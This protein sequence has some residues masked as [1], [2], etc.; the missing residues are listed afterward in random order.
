M[1]KYFAPKQIGSQNVN[2]R[3][4]TAEPLLTTV[5]NCLIKP[6]K[7]GTWPSPGDLWT[8]SWRK[9]LMGLKSE[10]WVGISWKQKRGQ[11]ERRMRVPGRR[12]ILCK[13]PEVEKKM[14]GTFNE[15]QTDRSGWNAKRKQGTD[16]GGLLRWAE[17][18]AGTVIATTGV[19]RLIRKPA[20]RVEWQLRT[21]AHRI[22]TTRGPVK[23]DDWA[24]TGVRDQ[25]GRKK[26]G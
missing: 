16:I 20:E 19:V 11:M 2:Q 12:K 17:A 3:N 14:H 13:G 25:R 4:V 10:V 22:P 24:K 15:L 18:R 26:Q 1:V 7:R 23:E 5:V 9:Y 8:V 21:E 6:I